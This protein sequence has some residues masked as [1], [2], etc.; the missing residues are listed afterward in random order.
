MGDSFS[1][2]SGQHGPTP[3]T[4]PLVCV[5]TRKQAHLSLHIYV[6]NGLAWG[7]KKKSSTISNNED[8]ILFFVV[9]EKLHTFLG[10]ES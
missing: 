6:T 5:S 2:K 9:M 1:R 8:M 7:K 10:E 4:T 3:F